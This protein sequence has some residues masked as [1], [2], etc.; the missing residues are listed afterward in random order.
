MERSKTYS[1]RTTFT[2]FELLKKMHLD[3][4]QSKGEIVPFNTFMVMKL[5][6]PNPTD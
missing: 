4:C 3:Y 1:V 5:L 6:Q 2:E